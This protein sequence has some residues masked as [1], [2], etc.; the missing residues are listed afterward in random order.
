MWP[1][2]WGRWFSPSTPHSWDP[3][4]SSASSSGSPEQERHGPVRVSPEVGYENDR[5]SVKPLLWR[6]VERVWVVYPGEEKALGRPYCGLSI[7]KGGFLASP[8][9]TAQGTAVL[10]WKGVDL[11]R[12]KGRRILWLK[13][14]DA[15][16]GC[17]GKWLMP[18]HLERSKVRLNGALSNL[19]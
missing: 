17:P 10:N 1:A 12:T 8:V 5:R 15:G 6:K 2:S 3:T 19:I 16:V 14:W 11:D 9:V 18:H 7:C 13:W 4:S